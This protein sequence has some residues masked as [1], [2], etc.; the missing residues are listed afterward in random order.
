[1]SSQWSIHITGNE[2][3]GM[4]EDAFHGIPE[5]MVRKSGN[6]GKSITSGS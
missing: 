3:D 1:M 5:I 2:L 4:G 6:P